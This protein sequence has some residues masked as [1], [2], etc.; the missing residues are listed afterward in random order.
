VREEKGRQ[1]LRQV[2]GHQIRR[3]A[4]AS[5]LIFEAL[6]S[7]SEPETGECHILSKMRQRKYGKLPIREG[8]QTRERRILKAVRPEIGKELVR[9]L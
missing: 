6:I 8:H 3:S 9:V 7:L 2:E 5:L 4:E 1:A